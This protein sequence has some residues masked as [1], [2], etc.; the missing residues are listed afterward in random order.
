MA[1][2]KYSGTLRT[3]LCIYAA[4]QLSTIGTEHNMDIIDSMESGA[5]K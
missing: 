1:A 3:P 5:Y 2:N 4:A